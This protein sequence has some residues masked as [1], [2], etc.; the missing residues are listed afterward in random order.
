MNKKKLLFIVNVDWFFL[1][2]RLPIAIEA[3]NQGYEVH[4]A[5]TI[6]NELDSLKKNG[7][8]VH[9]INLHRSRTGLIS[10][11]SEFK[12][13]LDIIRL[14][15]PNIVHLVTIKPVLLGGI[16]SRIL[17]VPAVVYAVSGLGYVFL[18]KGVIAFIIR[19]II[20]YLYQLAFRHKNKCVIFQNDSDQSMLSK[21]S[22]LSSNEVELI[23]GSGVD[24]SVFT[25]QSFDSGVPVIILAARL[26][27]DKGVKEFVEAAKLVN[28]NNNRA[29]FALVGEPDFDNP[30]SIQRYE[31]ENWK[32][33]RIIE[34]WG[35]REDME[36]VIPLSTIVVLPS[37]R[38]GFPKILIEA[39]ACGRPVV[40]TDVPG[41]RD[42]IEKDITGIIVPVRDYIELAK[43]IS[44]L[45]DNPTISRKMG[46]AGRLRAEEFFDI[47]KVV[48]KHMKI[49]E[50]LLNRL[51]V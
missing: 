16:A 3:I 4:I 7:L 5:T 2:H 35:H 14:I 26:L 22:L 1:S 47:N 34:L 6:A 11:I 33:E 48:E 19:K 9:P 46:N 37:Y 45:L 44:F 13:I 30:A 49:Y 32:N 39:A 18:K 24:L 10:V 23:N 36:K 50:D 41:C 17:N 8:I 43:K 42:A 40:T 38:E 20:I 31:L 21:L 27:K 25:Q 28:I 12:E 29:R 15:A 51:L